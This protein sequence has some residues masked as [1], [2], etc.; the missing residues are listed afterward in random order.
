PL[1]VYSTSKSMSKTTVIIICTLLVWTGC[2]NQQSLDLPEY[3]KDLEE[4]TIYPANTE[5]EASIELIREVIFSDRD[6]VIL[7][8]TAGIVVDND[9]RVYV[10]DQHANTVHVFDSDGSYFR[11]IGRQGEGPG[12]FL[13]IW[14]IQ[15]GDKFLHVQCNLQGVVHAYSF[16]NFE[17]SHTTSLLFGPDKIDELLGWSPNIAF[18]KNDETYLVQF[19]RPIFEV[20][21]E[22]RSQRLYTVSS[23]G[24]INSDLLLEMHWGGEY[25]TDINIPTVLVV[26]YG[27]T[28]LLAVSE[29][30]FYTLWTE[31]LVVKKYDSHG[32]YIS[33]FYH[34]VRKKELRRDEVMKQ[35]NISNDQQRHLFRNSTLPETWPTVQHFLLDDEKRFWIS[36]IIDDQNNYEWWFLK[37]TGELIDRFI[38]PKEKEIQFVK[39]GKIYV[40]ETD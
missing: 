7:G 12:E 2:S 32:N 20:S 18:I 39:N 19:Y 14:D 9:G 24:D 36:T 26:P 4:L 40:L 10:G 13:N 15:I 22:N 1:L 30:S 37:E 27:R 8:R 38:W 33:A 23:E 35:I 28:T 29:E 17:L 34:P 21:D 31:D 11:R 6:E 5:P 25:L 3:L 16:D